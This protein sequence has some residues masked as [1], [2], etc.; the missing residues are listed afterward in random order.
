MRNNSHTVPQFFDLYDALICGAVGKDWVGCCQRLQLFVAE[1]VQVCFF[2][3]L[4]QQLLMQSC[5]C[6]LLLL[7]L[8]LLLWA[9]QTGS[10]GFKCISGASHALLY[11]TNLPA[12]LPACCLTAALHW[13][14]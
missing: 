6:Q 10:T 12:T 8:L 9:L 5:S 2:R 4:G 1:A 7:L 11:S 14:V 3:V 13:Y